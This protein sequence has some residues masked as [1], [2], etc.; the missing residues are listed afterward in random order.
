MVWLGPKSCRHTLVF[1]LGRGS[2]SFTCLDIL[3]RSLDPAAPWATESGVPTCAVNRQSARGSGSGASSRHSR[4]L[5]MSASLAH[6]HRERAPSEIRGPGPVPHGVQGVVVLAALHAGA[7][8]TPMIVGGSGAPGW[9]RQA[10]A[11]KPSS[12]VRHR[13]A[14]V[15]CRRLRAGLPARARGDGRLPLAR[16]RR[17]S[18][19]L[20]SGCARACEMISLRLALVSLASL[21]AGLCELRWGQR[22]ATIHGS[23]CFDSGVR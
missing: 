2:A 8:P 1:S 11:A 9:R 4:Y 16:H 19:R 18:M 20:Q 23:K 12:E 21:L 3:S 14:A 6:A 17:R 22:T 5:T 15:G 10:R 13:R 7:R